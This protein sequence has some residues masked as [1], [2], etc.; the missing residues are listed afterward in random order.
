LKQKESLLFLLPPFFLIGIILCGIGYT[1]VLSFTDARLL[2]GTEGTHFIGLENYL[3][4]LTD[5]LFYISLKNNF[6]LLFI[7]VS[8]PIILGLLVAILLSRK[9]HGSTAFKAVFFFPMILSFAISG[10]IWTWIFRTSGGLI[11]TVLDNAYLGNLTQSWLSN[12]SL[13]IFS[14]GVGG[15]WQL[16]GYPIVLFSAGL[17][18]ISESMMDAARMEAS[19]F[20]M[21]RH[22][23]IPL[24]KPVILGVSTLMI[25][26]AFKV[27][28]LVFVMTHGGPINSTYVLAFLVYM[29]AISSYQ[30]GYGSAVAVVLLLLS[31]VCV[32]S[33]ILLTSKSRRF[34][35]P[36]RKRIKIENK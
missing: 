34:F 5:P 9:V 6:L 1:V 26:N 17:V 14:L 8:F 27:F 30:L 20:Q 4:L 18:D 24:L 31:L 12:P 29:D 21:Y 36:F 35:V 11:N 10:T 13:A 25:I 33:F 15:V 3:K 23:V 2:G 22:V 28:D 32:I 16:I 19:T 7:L